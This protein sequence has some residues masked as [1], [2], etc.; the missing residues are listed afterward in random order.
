MVHARLGRVNHH[1]PLKYALKWLIRTFRKKGTGS[2]ACSI[3]GRRFEP[4]CGRIRASYELPMVSMGHSMNGANR[5]HEREW[6]SHAAAPQDGGGV[7]GGHWWDASDA[8]G[9]EPLSRRDPAGSEGHRH[10]AR[11][12]DRRG[13][14]RR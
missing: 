3:A 5:E 1:G 13:R 7:R 12:Q 2:V 8:Q 6:H 10:P 11:R 14:G 9:R 4:T